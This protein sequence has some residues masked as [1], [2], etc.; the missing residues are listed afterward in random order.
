MSTEFKCVLMDLDKRQAAAVPE[1][2]RKAAA[3]QFGS[4]I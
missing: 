2:I 3:E 4:G 1:D